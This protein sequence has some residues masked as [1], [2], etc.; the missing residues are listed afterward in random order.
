M[1]ELKLK[2]ILDRPLP[3][4]TRRETS[5]LRQCVRSLILNIVER[6]KFRLQGYVLLQSGVR[7][8]IGGKLLVRIFLDTIHDSRCLFL[9]ALNDRLELSASM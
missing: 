5:H 7:L 2:I 4:L 9:L 8:K 6:G 3:L 1:L